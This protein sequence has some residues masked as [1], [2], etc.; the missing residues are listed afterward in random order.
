MSSV[1]PFF[2]KVFSSPFSF[3]PSFFLPFLSF[4]QLRI[5]SV[6]ARVARVHA[7]VN[8]S[9]HKDP[10]GPH[11]C[12]YVCAC[13]LA[14]ITGATQEREEPVKTEKRNPKTERAQDN[15]ENKKDKQARARVRK[16]VTRNYTKSLPLQTCCQFR[17]GGFLGCALEK[18]RDRETEKPLQGKD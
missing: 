7:Q 6:C 3:F 12:V 14:Q 5:K 9:I 4:S 16:Q 11:R 13:V 17:A 1:L 15:H 2:E 8:E 10:V 18:E